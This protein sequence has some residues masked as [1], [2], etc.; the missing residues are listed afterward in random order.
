M[1]NK[2]ELMADLVAKHETLFK[3]LFKLAKFIQKKVSSN[4]IF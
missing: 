3:Q 4:I 2:S 1:L